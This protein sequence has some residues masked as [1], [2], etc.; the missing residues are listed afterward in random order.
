MFKELQVTLYDIFGYL[1]P[2]AIILLGFMLIFWA[3][4]WPTT[5]I[6]VYVHPP[7]SLAVCAVLFAYLA[8]HL[9]QAVGNFLETLPHVK[10]VLEAKLPLSV[11]LN[12]MVYD[13]VAARFGEKAKHLKPK[14][15]LTLCDQSLVHAASLGEREIFVYR[16][17]FYRGTCVALGFFALALVIRLLWSP[18]VLVL[19]TRSIE[20]HRRELAVAAALAGLGSWLSFRRYLR[21]ACIK[22]VCCATRFLALVKAPQTATR[23]TPK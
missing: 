14:E 8:G 22:N 15:L 13:A 19:T 17:G 4:F 18:A 16:E 12:Q 21:F 20:F 23:D 6:W 1:L 5:P 11:E 10:T 9:G 3:I 2:G 7:L